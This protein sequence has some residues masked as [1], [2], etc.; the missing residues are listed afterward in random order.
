MTTESAQASEEPQDPRTATRRGRRTSRRPAIRRCGRRRPAGRGAPAGGGVGRGGTRHCGP[1]RR[2][3]RAGQGRAGS[4]RQAGQAG[5]GRTRAGGAERRCVPGDG[6]ANV[7]PRAAA[8]RRPPAIVEIRLVTS[9]APPTCCGCPRADELLR[10][11]PSAIAAGTPGPGSAELEREVRAADRRARGV[12]R[13]SCAADRGARRPAPPSRRRDGRAAPPA[14]CASR[15]PGS[16]SCSKRSDGQDAPVPPQTLAD[17]TA[18][19]DQSRAE[20]E[21]WR[22]RAEASDRPGRRGGAERCS[23]CGNR[24]AIAEPPPIAGSSCCWARWRAPRPGCA[25]SGI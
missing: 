24:P 7:R 25:A 23:D 13:R 17:L 11:R 18:E 15:A 19:R 8:D 20:A 10:P 1:D 12:R 14:G 16:V 21:M 22:Q 2:P 9:A 5:V 4:P 6:G 3:R